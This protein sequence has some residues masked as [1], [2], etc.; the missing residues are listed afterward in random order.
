MARPNRREFLM[1]LGAA[2]ASVAASPA[3]AEREAEMAY[4]RMVLSHPSLLGYWRFEG[5]LTDARGGLAGEARGGAPVFVDGATGGKAL[6]VDG[7]RFVEFGPSPALDTE[8]TTVELFFRLPSRPPSGYN[9]CLVGKRAGHDSTRFSIHVMSDLQAVAV[10]NGA[11]VTLFPPLDGPMDVGRWYHLAVV[12]KPDGTVAAID[13]VL[14]AVAP[15]P[16]FDLSKRAQAFHIGASTPSG[17]EAATCIVD[18]VAVYGAALSPAEIAAHV[19]AAGW[20][21]KR[22]KLEQRRADLERRRREKAEQAARVRAARLRE[23]LNDPAL[24]ADGEQTVYAGDHLTG[25][26]FGLGGIGA[27]SVQM[28]GKAER[29]IWQIFNN[30]AGGPIPDTFFAVGA[31]QAGGQFAMRALQRSAAGPIRG[32]QS[33]TFRG[34]YPFA[35]Y[36]FEDAGLPVQVSLEAFTPLVPLRARDS[37]I[38]CAVFNVT[39]ENPGPAEAEVVVL[40]TQQNAVGYTGDAPILL[41]SYRGYGGNRNRLVRSA[42][43]LQ[44]HMTADGDR[45]GRGWGDMVLAVVGPRASGSASWSSAGA[46]RDDLAQHG[47]LDGPEEAGPSP[48]GETLDGAVCST[49]RLKAGQSRTVTF[50][51]AW[52]FPNAHHGSDGAGWVHTGNMYANWWPDASAVAAEA[53]ARLKELTEQTHR[54]HG[55]VYETNVPYWLRDRLTS[56]LAVLR[57]KTCF[58]AADGYF[59]G[60]EGCGHADGCCHGSCTHVWHYAQAHARLFPELARKMRE[61]TYGYQRADG[62]L[63]HRHPSAETATD[64]QFGDILGAYREHLTSSDSA[65]L[66]ALWPKVKKAMEYAIGRWDK[67]EDG[68]LAGAQWNTL[69]DYLGG[70][71]SWMGTLYL[72]ALAACARMAEMHGEPELAQRYRAIRQSGA[73]RQDATLFNGEYYIQ[74]R[75][76][77]PHRDYGEGCHIDQVLG[78]W[79]ANQVGLPT[80]YPVEH[81]RSAL[82]ALLTHNFQARMRGVPQSPRKFVSDEDACLQ[83]ISWPRG[84]RPVPAM[85][86]GDEAMTG[87]EYAAS[88]TMV[89]FGLIREGFLVAKAVH[90]RY[91]GRMRTGLTPGD[92]ASWGYSGNPFGDDECGKYYARAMSV[93][94]LLLACQGFVYDGPAGV[95]GFRPVWKPENHRSFFSSAEGWGVYSQKRSAKRLDAT[96]AVRFWRL[97]VRELRF[98]VAEGHK[99]RRATVKLGAQAV[100]AALSVSGRECAVRLAADA[101]VAEGKTLAVTLA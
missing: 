85:L 47:R 46:L 39:V 75:D 42:R 22:R 76:P 97:R 96:L 16:S 24:M 45:K 100:P 1:K 30:F 92:T 74:I 84:V 63:P 79:W 4:D 11:A 88:A 91:D 50:V 48:A 6:L 101:T 69:D 37:A 43:S 14:C 59:G 61:S 49:V 98:E 5:D 53:I 21:E 51:L 54:F 38:P 3:G 62:G 2:A 35:R 80:A 94:S 82:R 23:L 36:D 10:W 20:G 67:D 34:E 72:A 15:G 56:Q 99:P 90:D 65:W 77:E 93:W 73:A 83:M 60:W 68:V 70:S 26:F 71:T 87:F 27:G 41:R 86:Y 18:E 12:S 13:G 58:W 32:M 64:G 81:V 55:A 7:G 66:D 78:E 25:I 95:I 19:D 89:Q 57:S 31:K 33:L 40:G 29:P 52:H 9:M 17:D 28:D 44:L 8:S